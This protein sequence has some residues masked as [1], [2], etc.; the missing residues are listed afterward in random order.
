MV[1]YLGEGSENYR[2]LISKAVDLWNGSLTGFN[3]KPIITVNLLTQPQRFSL[4]EGFWN[5]P[6]GTANV[7]LYDGQSVIYFSNSGSASSPAGIA[8][9]RADYLRMLESDIYI[10]TNHQETYGRNLANTEL[11]LRLSE[12]QGVYGLVDS[13]YLT[14][15]HEIGHALGLNHVPIAGNIMSYSYMP[16]IVN[17][18]KP[19]MILLVS[20]YW[21]PDSEDTQTPF[22]YE[23]S[24]VSPY[25]VVE[26]E[27]MLSAKNFFSDS[28][29][30]GEQD[31]ISLMCVYDFE[32]WNNY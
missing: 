7:N 21:D 14:I 19:T 24:D 27:D 20:I 9:R 32:D 1:L 11:I 15:I 6:N 28:V 8:Y 5:D 4:Q 16:G 18:W 17:H 31:R 22:V 3:R 30:L 25:M 12:E 23:D 10:N 2:D 13:T 29:K 26:R